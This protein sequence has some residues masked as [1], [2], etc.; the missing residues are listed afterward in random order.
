MI[1]QNTAPAVGTA[2][3]AKVQYII[4]FLCSWDPRIDQD[5]SEWPVQALQLMR[6]YRIY[7]ARTLIDATG[8]SFSVVAVKAEPSSQTEAGSLRGSCS[9]VHRQAQMRHVARLQQSG[10]SNIARQ[11][12]Q[13]MKLAY[14]VTHAGKAL[15]EK[16]LVFSCCM[17]DILCCTNT[18][19]DS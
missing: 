6:Q 8:A 11:K 9:L 3:A 10:H 1:H 19:A 17:V 2:T 16:T 13:N 15:H 14:Y 18:Y 12:H 7:F 5:P 4:A